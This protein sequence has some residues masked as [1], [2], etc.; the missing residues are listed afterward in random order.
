MHV[1]ASFLR[2][3]GFAALAGIL[4]SL[5]ACGG[6]NPAATAST[7]PQLTYVNPTAGGYRLV[8]NGG[9][10]SSKVLLDLVGPTG[11]KIQGGLVNLHADTTKVAWANPGGADAYVLPGGTLALGTGTALLKSKVAGPV[12]QAGL[13][14]KGSASA[15]T[16]GQQ[17]IFTVALDLVKGAKGT[18]S[19]TSPSAQILDAAGTTQAVTVAVGTL[20]AQ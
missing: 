2:P 10:T 12:L 1:R 13:F 15:A 9:S 4:V 17:A 14:Q 20:T 19:L 5:A 8:L 16:L 6:N 18:V 7:G 11:A 3:I